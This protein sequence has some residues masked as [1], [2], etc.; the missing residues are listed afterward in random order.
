MHREVRYP[1]Q[2][3]APHDHYISSNQDINRLVS[4]RG[5]LD[6]RNLGL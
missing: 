5:M 1:K 6:V 3:A 4:F 2:Q